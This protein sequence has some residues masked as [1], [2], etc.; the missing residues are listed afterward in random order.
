M[1]HAS[2]F[3]FKIQQHCIFF[4]I[5]PSRSDSRWNQHRNLHSPGSSSVKSFDINVTNWRIESLGRDSDSESEEEF[6]DCQ[7]N[8]S[9]VC[10]VIQAFSLVY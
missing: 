4:L 3:S 10:E 5:S 2:C 1:S 7:G 8:E 6:F 9:N